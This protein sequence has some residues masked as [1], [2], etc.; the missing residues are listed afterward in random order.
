MP[1]TTMA[2]TTR[3]NTSDQAQLG[4]PEDRHQPLGG[5]PGLDAERDRHA[6]PDEESQ[7]GAA[8]LPEAR[9][10]RHQRGGKP[11]A[12][13]DDAD[14]DGDDLEDDRAERER[15][16]RGPEVH[17]ETER[18]PDQELDQRG[19]L[20]EALDGQAGP[21]SSGYPVGRGSGR[22]RRSR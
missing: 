21:R 5:D 20:A 11:L 19:Q 16:E 12:H 18:G 2:V 13:P 7:H 17:A 1:T 4:S 6:Q 3:P 8:G 10:A 9:P 15:P 14:R 22:S